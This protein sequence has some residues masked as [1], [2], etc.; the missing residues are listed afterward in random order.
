MTF[1]APYTVDHYAY[2]GGGEDE[3][4]NKVDAW[5]ERATKRAAQG[6]SAIDT[7]K[8][9][10]NAQ[11]EIAEISLDLPP[12]WLPGIHDRIGLPDGNLYEVT[13]FDLQGNGFHGWKPGNIVLLKRATGII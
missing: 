10:P 5:S 3:L 6:F 7:E 8:L 9:G 12:D 4:G 13:G 1:P 2:I 11:G